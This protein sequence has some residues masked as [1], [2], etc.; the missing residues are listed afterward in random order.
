[1]SNLFFRNGQL[2]ILTLI[3]IVVW[4]LSSFFALP[5][6]EDPELTPR[7]AIVT[8]FLPG[9]SP[10]R[11]ETLVTDPIEQQLRELEEI[12]TLTSTSR[13]GISVIEVELKDTITN[14]DAAWSR[15]RDKA[16]DA[17]PSL[18]TAATEPEVEVATISANALIVGLVWDL[19]GDPNYGVLSRLAETLQEDLRRIPG[20]KSVE[21]F[22]EAEEEIRVEV[23]PVRLAQL[24]LTPQAV[25][26][27]LQASDARV[28]AGQV[29]GFDNQLLLEIQ[30]ELDSLER[31]RRTP[32]QVGSDGQVAYVG[33]IAQVRRGIREPLAAKAVLDGKSAVVVAA[34]VESQERVD[35][36]AVRAHAL[37][38]TVQE[39]LPNGIRLQVVLDQSRYVQARLNTVLGNLLIGAGLVIGV[40]LVIMGWRSSLIVG[41]ALPLSCLMVFGS[42]KAMGIPLHQI[43]ITGVIIALGLLIDNAIIMVD[44]VGI[45]LRAGLD[46]AQSVGQSVR[47]MAV[48]LLGS[49]LTTVLAFLPIALAPGAVGEFTGTIGTTVILAL[50]SSLMLA[51]TVIPA[52]VGRLGHLINAPSTA[53]WQIGFRSSTLSRGFDRSLRLT[54]GRPLLGILLGL[55]LPLAGFAVAPLLP[56]QFFPPAGRDQFYIELRL[57]IQASLAATEAMVAQ[58]RQQLLTHADVRQVSWFLGQAAPRFYY[59]VLGGQE[60]SPNYAQALVQLSQAAD[61]DLIR[62]LQQELDRALPTAQVL[63]RQLEQGPPFEAPIELRLYGPDLE[64]LRTLGDDLRGILAQTPQV[65]HTRAT[66]SEALPKL[67]LTLDEEETRRVGLTQAEV[68]RQLDGYLEGMTGGS[69]LEDNEELPVRVRVPQS[70][71]AQVEQVGSLDILGQQRIPLSTVGQVNLMADQA[72][73]ARR[74]GQRVNTI[75]G[76]T[77]AG[78]LPSQV[79]AAFQR[80]LDQSAFSLPPDYRVEL[81]G[82]ADARGSSIANLLSTVGV[83]SVLM[84]ATLVLSFNS[85]VSAGII[86]V[87]AACAAGLGLGS[88][89]LSGYPFGFTAILG[90]LGLVGLAINDS[91]VVLSALREH[92]LARWGDAV[93]VTQVVGRS[94]RHVVATTL[95]TLVGFIPLLFDATG[96]WP[97]LAICIAGGLGGTTILALYAVPSAHLL[98]N[99]SGKPRQGSAQA[100][101]SSSSPTHLS[102][103]PVMEP[104]L[105]Q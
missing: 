17:I 48:P 59:N 6:L 27:Q 9:A 81:G 91:I 13:L 23:D 47:H 97:P 45:R 95:T 72:V 49:T 1:M 21:R 74:Q 26:M 103:A 58:A 92:P 64:Q 42:M 71:R 8:T 4:G 14:V 101:E 84:L 70:V 79:L 24:G 25:A 77:P 66:L 30:G 11:M 10:E 60:N 75:Q 43:S 29:R 52:L 80:R 54:F 2:L 76:Y 67:G 104:G 36:W 56:Q 98:L 85:F 105:R 44:E 102:P 12:D 89:Y 35:E 33:D 34:Q 7:N 37:L 69:I 88:L 46:G 51:L 40:T 61:A 94:T 3:L 55:A 57:P 15:V 22:G 68:A 31:I 93:A 100:H 65:L 86:L 87:I 78:I 96:F 41:L 50:T 62:E 19:P 83:L 38:R 63:V 53:W 18:P 5:R 90:T 99:R 32:I 73:I 39:R 82:E 28:S 20:S 16:S